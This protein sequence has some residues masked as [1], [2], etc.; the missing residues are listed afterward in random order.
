MHLASQLSRILQ[1]MQLEE[2]YLEIFNLNH[3]QHLKLQLPPLQAAYS[4][5]NQ[6]MELKSQIQLL[7]SHK[8]LL[9]KLSKEAY[10]GRM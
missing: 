3:H 6:Q 7:Q 5:I 1:E 8:L 2:D 4:L 10:L 9:S